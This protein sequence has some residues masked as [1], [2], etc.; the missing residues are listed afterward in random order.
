MSS[1]GQSIRCDPVAA[2]LQILIVKSRYVKEVIHC[3]ELRD[4]C[5]HGIEPS[6]SIRGFLSIWAAVK[7]TAFLD[8]MPCSL[9]DPEDGG[10]RFLRNI[11]I[12]YQSTRRHISEDGD[13]DTAVR[14]SSHRGTYLLIEDSA[15]CS[16]TQDQTQHFTVS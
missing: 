2:G 11:D 8:V 7:I 4:A 15:A 3:L 16:S 9:E 10:S 5:G 13:L 14:T 6:D 12:I 1:H